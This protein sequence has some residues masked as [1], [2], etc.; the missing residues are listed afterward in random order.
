MPKPARHSRKPAIAA[1]AALMAA[2]LPALSDATLVFELDGAN[3]TPLEMTV[4]IARFFARVDSSDDQDRFLLFQAGKFFPLYSVNPK[5]G[6]YTLLTPPATP[7]LGSSGP[8]EPP[9]PHAVTTAG[10]AAATGSGPAP[11]SGADP[12]ADAAGED[13][14]HEASEGV[15]VHEQLDALSASG[16]KSDPA[17]SK[18]PPALPEKSQFKPSPKTDEIA[19]VRCRV[20]L[21]LIDGEPAIEHCMAN[22]AALG[23]TEREMRTL[24]RLFV[25]ARK[26][27]YDWLGAATED[28][29]FVSVRSRDMLRGK[30]LNLTSA[31][32]NA[33]PAGRLRVPKDFI[34]VKPAET[35]Q[36]QQDAA[37]SET[38]PV[39]APE[40]KDGEPAGKL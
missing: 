30:T 35:M 15:H 12:K 25:M 5:G 8:Q 26:R 13:Q 4:S 33:L 2:S 19:G 14:I 39:D 24:A 34:E 22:K 1:L 9:D 38:A 40:A 32:T 17:T 29:D 31:S 21:E 10:E 23:M 36:P 11:E 20:I 3:G 18:Q 7:T 27:G 16:P 37:A 28:E 6:T